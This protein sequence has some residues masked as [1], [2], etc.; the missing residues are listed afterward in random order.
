MKTP[1]MTR[2]GADSRNHQ[3]HRREKK[4]GEEEYRCDGTGQARETAERRRCMGFRSHPP[5]VP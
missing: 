3:D 1:T 4:G 2:T 5:V